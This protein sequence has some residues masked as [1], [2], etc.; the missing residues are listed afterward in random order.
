MSEAQSTTDFHDDGIISA[1][2]HTRVS[3][4]IRSAEKRTSGEIYAVIA[5]ASDDYFYV[6][7]FMAAVW[8]LGA[9]ITI[10]I[11]AYFAAWPVPVWTIAA[12][13]GLA[14]LVI[15]S[16]FAVRPQWRLFF[17]PHAI[18]HRRASDNA[19]RQFLAHGIH[20]TAD[21]SGVLLVV[22]LAEHHAQVVADAG[23]NEK[24]QQSDWD[25]IVALLVDHAKQDRMGDG[26]VAAIAATGDLL[27]LHLPPVDG[28]QNDLDDRLVEI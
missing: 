24:V 7:G 14:L 15:L 20:G 25:E 2:D 27:A 5:H 19:M 18:A 8:T 21:R 9:A 1:A 28:D 4:A 22:S 17:V 6:A 26:F 10:A 16:A 3:D 11:A 23:I 13:Q 12:A